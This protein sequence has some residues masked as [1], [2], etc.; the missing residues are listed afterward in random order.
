[1]QFIDSDSA[2]IITEIHNYLTEKIRVISSDWRRNLIKSTRWFNVYVEEDGLIIVIWK[3]NH[4]FK[5]LE[6][7][8][9]ARMYKYYPA[10]L[11][12]FGTQIAS[13]GCF[14]NGKHN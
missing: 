6:P 12:L 11:D 1:M 3:Y 2:E 8:I 9:I 10:N 14:L 13:K 4:L 7:K 5:V